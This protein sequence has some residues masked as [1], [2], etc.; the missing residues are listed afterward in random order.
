MHRLHSSSSPHSPFLSA[1]HT[2]YKH[3]AERPDAEGEPFVLLLLLLLLLPPFDL[4]VFMWLCA[5][6]ALQAGIQV[7]SP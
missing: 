3:M 2:L 7:I 4:W 6:R 1:V 5:R